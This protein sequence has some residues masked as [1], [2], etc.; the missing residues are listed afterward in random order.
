[1]HS[2]SRLLSWQS[3]DSVL[4]LAGQ[5]QFKLLVR[6]L[7]DR[8]FNNEIVSVDGETLPLIMTV[9]WAIALP[10]LVATIFL[11][12]AYH[13]FRPRPPIPPFWG[14]VADHYGFVMY[15][16]VV[17]GGI[18][19]FE[20]DLL[21]PNVLD[22]FVLSVL[23]IAER[24]LLLARVAAVLTFLGLF[25][26]GTSSLGTIFF[27]LATEPSDAPRAYAAHFLAVTTAG[28]CA[29]SMV[30]AL[31]GLFISLLGARLFRTI[32]SFLQSL[33]MMILS[34]V[35]FM[36][37]VFSRSL[38]ALIQSGGTA[39]RCFPPFW[40]L[41]VYE[42][43]LAGPS[44]L[45]AFTQLAHTGYK[46]TALL[47]ALAIITYPLAYARST[48]Q[49]VEGSIAPNTRSRFVQPAIRALH[50]TLVRTPPRRAV[51]HFI[52]QTLFRSQRH[53]LYLAMYAGIGIAL[54]SVWVVVLR[55]EGGHIRI[56][57]SPSGVRLA[58]PALAF[59][60]VAGLCTSLLSPAD[61]AGSWVFRL[62]H[63]KASTDH[64]AATKLWVLLWAMTLTLGAVAVLQISSYP[65]LRAPRELV[66]QVLV[67][68]GICLLLTDAFS[69]QTATIPFTEARVPRNTDLGFI[70][71]RYIV[72]FPALV[73]ATV[74]YEWWIEVSAGHLI[75]TTLGIIAAHFA[76]RYVQWRIRRERVSRSVA[77]E[78]GEVS[79]VLGLSI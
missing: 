74:N 72:F 71:L 20:W 56:A 73:V 28:L 3:D 24:R 67:A 54:A 41:G 49:A 10:T 32:S 36:F 44:A 48:R 18:T 2:Q 68:A 16:W 53:R 37:P 35:L 40:F 65:Q 62:I 12:P 66:T 69:L 39:V 58:V 77:Q 63:G 57:I 70:L 9:A 78:E 29:A 43:I 26:I 46:A 50:A 25:L 13:A 45:P 6:H 23:P 38:E 64:L 27:P 47:M 19:V 51:Y 22:V 5:K 21:V 14:R 1:M 34:T 33:V 8:F 59:W 17:M 76:L 42:S 7:L 60:I 52:S 55:I 11:F 75:V 31:Q 79:R 15:S 61:P 30:L 4:S